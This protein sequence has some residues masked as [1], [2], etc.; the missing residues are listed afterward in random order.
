VRVGALDTTRVGAQTG[1]PTRDD[2]TGL[3]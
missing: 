1:I 2:L 3:P